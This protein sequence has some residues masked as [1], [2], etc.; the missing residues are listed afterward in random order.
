MSFSLKC[1]VSQHAMLR[2]T[3]KPHSSA[4]EMEVL[5]S[6]SG[7]YDWQL[8]IRNTPLKDMFSARPH[9]IRYISVG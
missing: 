4:P 1:P 7:R 3:K 8:M 6:I 2:K 9:P 5:S